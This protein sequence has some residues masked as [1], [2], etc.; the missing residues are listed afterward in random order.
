M[1]RFAMHFWKNAELDTLLD[2][3]YQ[4]DKHDQQMTIAHKIQALLAENMVTI[5]I[6]S[7]PN[8]YQYNTKRFTGWWNEANPKGR[9]MIWEG[10]PERVLHVLDLKP[11]AATKA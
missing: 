11:V 1:P 6:L 4:T 3:F 10:T 7:G 9:P 5:P 8:F 2:S